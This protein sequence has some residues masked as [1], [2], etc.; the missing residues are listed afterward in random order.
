MPESMAMTEAV[1]DG[2]EVASAAFF[3]SFI[4]GALGGLIV[5]SKEKQAFSNIVMCGSAM[6]YCGEM[7]FIFLHEFWHG[8]YL[9]TK[10]LSSLMWGLL[11]SAV[12]APAMCQL[13]VFLQ[14]EFD[15]DASQ[16]ARG[17]QAKYKVSD[18]DKT[19]GAG[20]SLNRT[21]HTEAHGMNSKASQ[22]RSTMQYGTPVGGDREREVPLIYNGQSMISPYVPSPQEPSPTQAPMGPAGGGGRTQMYGGN[23]TPAPGVLPGQQA[24]GTRSLPPTI[25]NDLTPNG[26]SVADL[27]PG[28]VSRV[29]DATGRTM[30]INHELKSFSWVPPTDT[31]SAQ[32]SG[33]TPTSVNISQSRELGPAGTPKNPMI[34][35]MPINSQMRRTV[36]STWADDD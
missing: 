25:T 33:Y 18:A 2:F 5:L 12:I 27:P 11:I 7:G 6:A 8:T 26:K 9:S 1:L 35:A 36:P 13:C 4:A 24:D 14:T 23:A 16:G 28:W 31:I 17:V 3:G 22:F 21:D 10:T 19:Q 15:N 34:A 32:Q 29:D 20:E 30:Y